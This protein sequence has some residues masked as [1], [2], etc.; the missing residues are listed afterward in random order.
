MLAL[1]QKTV[2]LNNHSL[3]KIM[4]K[5]AS[6]LECNLKITQQNTNPQ[7]SARTGNLKGNQAVQTYLTKYPLFSSKYLDFFVWEK[8]LN[9]MVNK[10]HNNNEVILKLK[11]KY[12]F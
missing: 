9:M 10:E 2:S 11:K 7:Y 8:V 4:S 1:V 5:I 6:F 12:E 3:F